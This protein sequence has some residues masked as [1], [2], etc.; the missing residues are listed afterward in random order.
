VES[1]SRR[2]VSPPSILRVLKAF[3][4]AVAFLYVPEQAAAHAPYD[5]DFLGKTVVFLYGAKPDKTVDENAPL[6]TG[7]LM[8]IPDSSRLGFTLILVTARHIV[9]PEW[10][11]CPNAANPDV[12]FARI[13]NNDSSG[14]E[15]VRYIPLRLLIHG[16]PIWFRHSRDDIDA[17]VLFFPATEDDLG[18][19]DFRALPSWRLPT[20]EEMNQ[21]SIGDDVVSAGMLLGLSGTQRNYP[22]FKF[23]KI[24]NILAED[25]Q[26]SCGG[27]SISV[28]AWLIAANLVPGNSGSPIFYYPP[29]GENADITSPGL[30]RMV[31]IGIQSSSALGSDVAYMTPANFVFQIIQ[32]MNIKDADLYRGKERTTK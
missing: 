8:R 4:L 1:Q 27:M 5:P 23:G 2:K 3:S 17:A 26:T 28:K 11:H 31:L 12:M 13:N 9:D 15:K 18:N 14:T 16:Q 21:L 24:S 30:Q 20:D 32:K 25:V 22:V 7:F 6:G 19:G 29:F 10:A